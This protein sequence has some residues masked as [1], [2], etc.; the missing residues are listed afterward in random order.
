M[1]V[2]WLAVVG[3][4]A[5]LIRRTW[6]ASKRRRHV[7]EPAADESADDEEA[8]PEPR[9]A[10]ADEAVDSLASAV[11]AGRSGRAA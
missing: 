8:E 7:E 9:A 5:L 10:E 6:K 3:A 1:P 4:V 2:F 11:K